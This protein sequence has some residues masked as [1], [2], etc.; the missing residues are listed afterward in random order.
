MI[1][2][3]GVH[4]YKGMGLC[5]ADFIS[6]FLFFSVVFSPN[7]SEYSFRSHQYIKG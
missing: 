4:M 3:K 7:F 6:F 1:S 5:F 2:E